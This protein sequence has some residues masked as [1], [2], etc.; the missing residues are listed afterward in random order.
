M[1]I[2]DIIDFV[3]EPKVL[4]VLGVLVLIIAWIVLTP[5]QKSLPFVP[6]APSGQCPV[7]SS[8]TAQGC[9]C[10]AGF[11]PSNDLQSCVQ[12][13]NNVPPQ[14][15]SGCPTNSS[16]NANG[17]CQC[18]AGFA[19][20]NSLCVSLSEYCAKTFAGSSPKIDGTGCEC[21]SPLVVSPDGKSC[22]VYSGSGTIPPTT[23]IA[24]TTQSSGGVVG[25]VS[26]TVGNIVK[27]IDGLVN[28]FNSTS[29]LGSGLNAIASGF[30]GFFS[31]ITNLVA[32]I[33]SSISNTFSGVVSGT[34]NVVGTVV[35]TVSGAVGNVGTTLTSVANAVGSTLNNLTGGLVSGATSTIS[36][37]YD[38]ATS[39][40]NSGINS[41][42]SALG[43]VGTTLQN[44][45][46]TLVNTAQNTF[47]AATTCS[48]QGGWLFW[49]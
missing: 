11:V 18:N 15:Q 24:P 21:K 44:G 43:S 36:N 13:G 16:L 34:Q 17:Q 7:N 6:P 10:N 27:T 33:P 30:T 35:N 8:L 32:T 31:P 46:T 12:S 14:P 28:P 9:V 5:S 49:C 37:V 4:V 48:S 45:V 39:L 41:V 22:V 42:S 23:P 2:E 19:P 40:V 38:G 1:A 29:V 26:D 3:K 25:F 47:N 20:L